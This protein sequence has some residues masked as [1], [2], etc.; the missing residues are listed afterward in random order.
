MFQFKTLAA[1]PALVF[2]MGGT[3]HAALTVDQVW[4]SW[5]DGAALAGLTV[6]A[7]TESNA[8]GVLTLNGVTIA[9]Q[10]AASGFTISDM[11]LT[12]QSD[13]TVAI[14]PGASMGLDATEGSNVM[15]VAVAHDGLVITAS[16][17]AGALVYDFQAAGVDIN[18]DIA[19]EGY[20]F[21]DSAPAPV[22][23][24][25]G[26]IGF[27]ALEGSYTDTAGDNRVFGLDL[28]AA[29][30][31]LDTLT[32]DPGMGM[33]TSSVSE[34]ADFVAGFDVTL[35]ST[36]PMA[37]LQ[38]SAGFRKALEEGFAIAVTFGQGE[39]SGTNKQ[40]SDFFPYEMTM[41]TAGGDGSLSF[42]KDDFTLV[43]QSGAVQLNVTS[44]AFPAPMEMTL[45]EAVMDLKVPVIA[46]EPQDVIVKMKLGQLAL[47]EGVWGMF[48]PGAVLNREAADVNIDVSGRTT[49][50]I[51]ALAE[52]EDT[53]V[54]APE[55]APE[56]LDITDI[57]LKVAGAALNAT[58]AF[59]FD[60]SM[61]MP[62]PVGTAKVNVDGA[63]ALIDGL[64]KTGLVQEQ[65]AM[66][67]R[68]MMGMFMVPSGN[69]DDSLTSDIEVKEGMQVFVNGQP[70]PM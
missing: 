68:M 38:G 22:I 33:K 18:Y 23:K 58:G 48:D 4:Q 44:A 25:T 56:K 37:E 10:G 43:S 14:A 59:T 9:P 66:G 57:T 5:K 7:A 40:E 19:T 27:E 55:P 54:P 46:T 53:G 6:T 31:L 13:G 36:T 63:N 61:G 30:L 12:E 60:N 41:S 35:P 15:K 45:A 20:S 11:T 17:N 2:L 50:D 29:K 52:A 42:D 64:I 3:A 70:L 24:N 67:V 16:E 32:D 1:V 65:D 62:M 49:L 28:K 8:G 39:S 47:S 21:D 69:G 51:L 34:T 26:K